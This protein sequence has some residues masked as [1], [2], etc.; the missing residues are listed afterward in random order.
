MIPYPARNMSNHLYL[1]IFRFLS[2]WLQLFSPIGTF[3]STKR[4][5]WNRL[6]GEILIV[7]TFFGLPVKIEFL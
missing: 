3:C 6:V 4:E 7:D 2:G 1:I 5:F